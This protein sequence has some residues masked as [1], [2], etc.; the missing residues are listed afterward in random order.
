MASLFISSAIAVTLH[1]LEPWQ[2]VWE[3]LPPYF[4][5]VFGAFAAFVAVKLYRAGPQYFYD[6][7]GIYKKS[8]LLSSW[9]EVAALKMASKPGRWEQVGPP[10]PNL[11]SY[12]AEN[13]EFMPQETTDTSKYFFAFV[14]K[15]GKEI[16]RAP[17]NPSS[18]SKDGVSQDIIDTAKRAGENL[19]IA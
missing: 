3:V 10:I 8:E 5:G 19:T 6:E 14:G 9:H 13:D 7:K 11:R 17:T 15:E 4:F 2:T 18:F 1:P 12:T 16:A